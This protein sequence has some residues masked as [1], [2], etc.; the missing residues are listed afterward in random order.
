M[1]FLFPQKPKNAAQWFFVVSLLLIL[2][3]NVFLTFQETKVILKL[4]KIFPYNN[5][6]QPFAG[7]EKLTRNITYIGYYTDQSLDEKGPAKLFAQAQLMLAPAVL[8]FNNLNR[9]YLLLVC[10]SERIALEKIKEAGAVAITKN[11]QDMIFARK[12]P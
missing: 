9:P 11:N 7:L 5:I 12:I 8:D 1:T 6:G 10:S 4:K 3:V 2:A